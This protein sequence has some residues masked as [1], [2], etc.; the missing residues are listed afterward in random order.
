MNPTRKLPAEKFYVFPNVQSPSQIIRR[1]HHL[2]PAIQN[3]RRAP[4]FHGR[5][6][7]VD[8]RIP[9]KVRGHTVGA[10]PYVIV[11]MQIEDDDLPMPIDESLQNLPQFSIKGVVCLERLLSDCWRRGAAP[12]IEAPSISGH[13][14]NRFLS[15]PVQVDLKP[16]PTAKD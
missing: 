3:P 4:A 9:R 11:T 5:R 6:A 10:S 2:E 8:L 14:I 7:E 1:P 16:R 12:Y 15:R 13:K